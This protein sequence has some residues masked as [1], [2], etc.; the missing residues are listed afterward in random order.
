ME[1]LYKRSK[2]MQ[3]VL[4]RCSRYTPSNVCQKSFYSLERF[5][6]PVSDNMCYQSIKLASLESCVS[7]NKDHSHLRQE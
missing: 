7:I 2:I 3:R 4:N 5:R 6:V 1:K